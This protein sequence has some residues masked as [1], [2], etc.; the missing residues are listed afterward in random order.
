MLKIFEKFAQILTNK[1]YVLKVTTRL[2]MILHA[3][4]K[5]VCV[6]TK[7]NAALIRLWDIRKYC[8]KKNR[9]DDLAYFNLHY[10]TPKSA[11]EA[12]RKLIRFSY[13]LVVCCTFHHL[14]FVV[15]FSI[16]F[17]INNVCN[18]CQ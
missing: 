9:I 2:K 7:T 10:T 16:T 15:V 3:V 4:C 11:Y 8:T 14:L 6:Q 13:L 1:T 18:L 17:I 5:W 12:E